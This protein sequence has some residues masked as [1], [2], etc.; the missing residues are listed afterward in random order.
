MKFG[1]YY[2]NNKLIKW[3]QKYVNYKLLKKEIKNSNI[4][5]DIIINT[6]IEKINDF[7]KEL[8]LNENESMED[9]C[10]FIVLN[11]M[12]LFKAIKKYDKKLCKNMK[13]EFFNRI[14]NKDF[15]IFYK[16]IPRT[17]NKVKLVIFDKDGT[18]INHEKL[19][20]NW[21]IK[22]VNNMESLI[23][24]KSKLYNH[25]GFDEKTK[26]FN[27]GSIIAKGTN[28][29]I[30]NSIYNFIIKNSNQDIELIKDKIKR[31]WVKL[32]LNKELIEECGNIKK[33]FTNLIDKGIKIAICTSD[34]RLPTLETLKYLKVDKYI[35]IITCGDDPI[36]SKPSPE[37]IWKICSSLEINPSN[38]IMV[39]DTI[40][41]IHAGLNAKC[42]KI[43]GVLSG[44]YNG[45]DLNEAD[46]VIDNIDNLIN[47]IKN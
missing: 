42:G 22:L 8:N 18:L 1:K 46:V 7:I 40:S 15:F 28:D 24:C 6:E 13:L 30:R 19:F 14:K 45:F 32:E 47:E 20:L 29:D 17:M 3:N 26:S 9:I 27:S 23:D 37:P 12:A 39:G 21:T 31:K 33:V 16:S 35:D 44:G 5:I 43:I 38:S 34:D 36:S 4:K 41:D 2:K 11:Y 25:L 10:N